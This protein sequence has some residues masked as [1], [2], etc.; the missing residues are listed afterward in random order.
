MPAAIFDAVVIVN[1]ELLPG[2]TLLLEKA[3][4]M[5]GSEE[6]AL[7][8]TGSTNPST[9]CTPII[10]VALA[11][12]A[13]VCICGVNE[14][15][16]SPILASTINVALAALVIDPLVPVIV[17]GYV[18]GGVDALTLIGTVTGKLLDDCN[19]LVA[20]DGNPVNLRSIVPENPF[21]LDS[22]NI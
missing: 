5:P 22:L 11:P 13:T 15:A 2:S 7:N 6:L 16:K 19:V 10:N 20:P 21:V 1:V 4:L 18:P 14:R 12:T 17:N 3:M 9:A 8:V